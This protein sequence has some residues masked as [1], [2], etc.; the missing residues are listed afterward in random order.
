MMS[1][2][3]VPSQ[4]VWW[5]TPS[6]SSASW[7]AQEDPYF[8]RPSFGD[9]P[10][11][12]IT[13]GVAGFAANELLGIDDFRR[14]MGRF[15]EGN[16]AGG[17]GSLALGAGELG[18]TLASLYGGPAGVG[19]RVLG[20]ATAGTRVAKSLGVLRQVYGAARRIPVVGRLVERLGRMGLPGRLV[21]AGAG[22]AAS[23]LWNYMPG[24]GEEEGAAEAEPTPSPFVMNLPDAAGGGGGTG[25]ASIPGI[26]MS[27]LENL[28]PLS[29]YEIALDNEIANI[30]GRAGAYAQAMDVEWQR[31]SS[32]NL[33]AVEKA[34]RLAAAAGEE[35]Y[36]AWDRAAQGALD[37]TNTRNAALLQMAGGMPQVEGPGGAAEDFA[38]FAEAA[39]T[40]EQQLQQTL[41]E[42]RA[43]DY[44]YLSQVA[45]Q[46]GAAYQGEIARAEQDATYAAV[47]RHNERVAAR[48]QMIASMQFQAAMQ[49]QQLAAQ[50]AISG[51]RDQ[52]DI[53]A[54]VLQLA[55]GLADRT[56]T[57][58]QKGAMLRRYY[59]DV[60]PSDADAAAFI[61]SLG[62]QSIT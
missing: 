4:D 43:E 35:G 48:N 2:A 23:G 22:P 62:R 15:G 47:A 10:A 46:T 7:Y 56:G 40:A 21:V 1:S 50:A 3:W 14:A 16:I 24:E 52:R 44:R 17:L 31:I 8:I 19:V 32:V 28:M 36:E 51:A 54:E 6:E 39:G 59:P 12:N 9:T 49:Q 53:G 45:G 57:S 18:L 29:D 37:V 42:N 41:G 26:D 61:D 5:N 33:A 38:R 27:F 30:E 58:A 20:A 25:V 55:L 13:E 34:E 11:Q 60:F